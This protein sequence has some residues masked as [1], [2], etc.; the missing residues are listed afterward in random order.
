MVFIFANFRFADPDDLI[1]IPSRQVMEFV[2]Q[3]KPFNPLNWMNE[4][5]KKKDSHQSVVQ[6]GGQTTLAESLSKILP[7]EKSA[8]Q[9][10]P[11]IARNIIG[12]VPHRSSPKPAEPDIPPNQQHLHTDDDPERP[13]KAGLPRLVP[14]ELHATP[15]PQRSPNQR[16]EKQIRFADPSLPLLGEIL[17]DAIRRKRRHV[18]TD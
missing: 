11:H 4:A 13:A 18:R 17:V 3:H 12:S 14:K 15:S 8:P 5:P 10:R 1:L 7:A 2:I 9:G 16:V 6:A